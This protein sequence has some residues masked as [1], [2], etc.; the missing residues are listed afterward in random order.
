M[1]PTRKI[2]P[3]DLVRTPGAHTARCI[4]INDDRSRELEDVF[5]GECMSMRPELLFLVRSAPVHRWP[6][7]DGRFEPIEAAR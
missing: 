1:L 2:K 5:T 4:G 3:G 7:L 6:P